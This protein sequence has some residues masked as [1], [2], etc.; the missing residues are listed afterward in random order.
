MKRYIQ[1]LYPFLAGPIGNVI[2]EPYSSSV[3]YSIPFYEREDELFE[4]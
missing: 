1:P 2:P 4:N 3:E